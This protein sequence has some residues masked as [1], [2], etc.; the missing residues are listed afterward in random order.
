MAT[1]AQ[2]KARQPAVKQR[3]RAELTE[4]HC[5]VG[6]ILVHPPVIRVVASR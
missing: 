3:Y 1:T 5:V 6:R 2:W 4:R